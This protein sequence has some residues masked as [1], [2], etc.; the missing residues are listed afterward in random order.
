MIFR[1]GVALHA[2]VV[3]A[4]VTLTLWQ[5]WPLATAPGAWAPHDLGDPLLSTWT[6]WWNATHVP[7]THDWW[8]GAIF[9]PA[10]GALALSDHRVG[11]GLITTPL[12]LG[13]V[14]PLAA[15][16]IAFLASYV[17]SAVSAYALA[18]SLTRSAAAAFIAGLVYGF[19]PFRSEHLPHLELLS[20]YWLPLVLLALH[21][22]VATFRRRWL[23]LLAGSLVLVAFTTGY[24]FFFLGV[25]LG[26]WLLWFVPWDLPRRRYVELGVALALPFVPLAPVLLAYRSTHR[27]FGLGRSITEIEDLSADIRGWVTPPEPLAFWNAPAAWHTPE[28]AVFPGVTAALLVAIGIG[29]AWREGSR[30]RR[31]S[32]LRSAV[33][34]L[35]LVA[36]GI[37]MIPALWGAVE[38]PLGPFRLSVSQ[39]YKPLSIATLLFLGW[40]LTSAPIRDARK[41]YSTLAFYGVATIAMAV[42]ALGPTARLMGE[43]VLYKAPYAWLMLLP[44]FADGFRAPARFAM[45]VALCLSVAAAL[46]FVRLTRRTTSGTRTLIAG[47]VVAGVLIDSWVYPFVLEVPPAPLVVPTEVP[48]DATVLELPSGVFE[49]AAAMYRATMHGRPTVNGLSGYAPPHYGALQSAIRD[50]DTGALELVAVD[51]PLAVFVRKQQASAQFL[52]LLPRQSRARHLASTPTHEVFLLTAAGRAPAPMPDSSRVVPIAGIHASV[53]A[54]QVDRLQDGNRRTAWI[55]DGPQRGGE[56]LTI[57]LPDRQLVSGVILAHGPFSP[58]FPRQLT[59]DVAEEQGA[60]QPGLARADRRPH[61]RRRLRRP[62]R[63]ARVHRVSGSGGAVPAAD[64]DRAFRGGRV[65]RGRAQRDRASLSLLIDDSR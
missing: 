17:L 14:T 8:N 38:V 60:W 62:A 1:T 30:P 16:N 55:S 12:I 41:A 51:R 7:F 48:A 61:G 22:W 29:I 64:A 11:I 37:A 59:I 54:E 63:R 43:R 52:S 57:R 13:G 47:V 28:G 34:G 46:A 65:G 21:R 39:A 50:E 19:H 42:L 24:Y 15:H 32:R 26:L 9:Y 36:L 35:G 23:A 31:R 44:G 58:G 3:M 27:Q 33:L 18:F 40:A 2:A 10:P 45:L 49:D 5:T 53:R 56:A 20:G 4:Y 6:L 25:L